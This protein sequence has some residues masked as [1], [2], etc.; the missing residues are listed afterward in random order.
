MSMIDNTMGKPER[1]YGPAI[2]RLA[3]I[4]DKY[5]AVHPPQPI[6]AATSL[7]Y[8]RHVLRLIY[9]ENLLTM[10]LIQQSLQ[11]CL[12]RRAI[13]FLWERPAV[14]GYILIRVGHRMWH[15]LDGALKRI[16]SQQPLPPSAQ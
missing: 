2:A 7:I 5:K 3:A 12:P 9:V 16:R 13:D 15:G 10:R 8:R 11:R 4:A 14:L 6:N 1:D